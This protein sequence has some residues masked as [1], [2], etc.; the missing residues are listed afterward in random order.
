MLLP[1]VKIGKHCLV[2]AG[3]IVGKNLDDY[4]LAVGTPA[5]MIKD[6]R[7]I[8]DRETGESHYPWPYRFSRG[9]PWANMG[10]DEWI[11]MNNE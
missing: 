2:G 3:S 7:E 11:Q 8:K 6:V 9:M 10:F 4:Q 5:K 1:G